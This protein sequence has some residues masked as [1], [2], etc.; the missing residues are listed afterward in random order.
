MGGHSHFFHAAERYSA[1]GLNNVTRDAKIEAF[2]AQRERIMDPNL[3]PSVI[4]ENVP[5]S[6][7]LRCQAKQACPCYEQAQGRNATADFM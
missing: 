6:Q 7:M 1:G 4:P 5:S 2:R 3:V